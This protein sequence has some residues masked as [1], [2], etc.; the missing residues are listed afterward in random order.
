MERMWLQQQRGTEQSG[1]LGFPGEPEE[2]LKPIHSLEKA[3][4]QKKKMMN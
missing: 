2:G 4:E 3:M 1:G